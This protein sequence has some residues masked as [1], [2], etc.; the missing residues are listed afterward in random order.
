MADNDSKD[1][2]SEED[3]LNGEESRLEEIV[4]ASTEAFRNAASKHANWARA[5]GANKQL[6]N[7]LSQTAG[8]STSLLA[9]QAQRVGRKA[10]PEFG[11]SAYAPNDLKL[12][13]DAIYDSTAMQSVLG[14]QLQG[15]TNAFQA[16]LFPQPAFSKAA[17]RL[18]K[19]LLPQF[20]QIQKIVDSLNAPAATPETQELITG[21]KGPKYRSNKRVWHY[22]NAHAL[23]QILFQ[24][25][26]WASNPKHL[27]D[28]SELTHGIEVIT[29]AAERASS[30]QTQKRK[31]HIQILDQIF[32]T[33]FIDEAIHEVYYISASREPD[34]LTLW[35]N[36][37]TDT[38]FAIGLQPGK[39]LSSEGIILAE[40]DHDSELDLPIIADWYK[41]E[42]NNRKK[43]ALGDLF[44]SSALEDIQNA[45]RDD[46]DLVVKELRKHLIVLA[47][48]MKHDAF[49]DEREVRWITT[50]WAPV[51]TVHYEVTHRGFVP[52]LH[53][54]AA[55]SDQASST[56]PITGVRCAPTSSPTVVRTIQGL[57]TQ[58]G[59][60]KAA[61]DVRQSLMPF[62]G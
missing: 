55:V 42:Y 40:Q 8:I 20:E 22:T 32:D 60:A 23:N 41:V 15:T 35:R 24:D 21:S 46:E 11:L 25:Y 61:N 34:S 43:D 7:L 18:T 36:Y 56:L 44:V 12:G 10:M 48:T 57:L 16:N 51:V 31:R 5:F 9:A 38:G 4:S 49:A 6:A 54:K 62:S 1:N 52:V 37:S 58:R 17:S 27:N 26:L 13:I 53:V 2:Q 3:D 50:N 59:Y 30:G 33:N 28:S 45:G 47:S 29:R 19:S 14:S 39:E